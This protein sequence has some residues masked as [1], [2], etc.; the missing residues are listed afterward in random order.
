M[1]IIDTIPVLEE[2]TR[3][4]VL[5]PPARVILTRGRVEGADALLQPGELQIRLREDATVRMENRDGGERAAVLLDYGRELH[6]GVRLLNWQAAGASYPRVS[7]SA[8][9]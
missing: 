2:D 9:R 1:R 7:R 3:R 6:G 4:R 8:R 5:V